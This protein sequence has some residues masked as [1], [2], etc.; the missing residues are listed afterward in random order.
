MSAGTSLHP[1]LHLASPQ[2]R[3][4]RMTVKLLGR[5]QALK[6][7]KDGYT[8]EPLEPYIP[9]HR[10]AFRRVHEAFK[11][12]ADVIAAHPTAGVARDGALAALPPYRS[13]GKGRGRK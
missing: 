3:A 11:A 13:R 5:R 8:P 4:W 6:A 9:I 12:V 1:M 7:K 10:K 2:R